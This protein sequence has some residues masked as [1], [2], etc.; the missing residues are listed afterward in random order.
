MQT[1]RGWR[2]WFGK[3]RRLA[4]PENQ[5]ARALGNVAR[6]LESRD[7]QQCGDEGK[8]RECRSQSAANAGCRESLV[9]SIKS[10]AFRYRARSDVDRSFDREQYAWHARRFRATVWAVP[11]GDTPGK[12]DH[13]FVCFNSALEYILIRLADSTGEHSHCRM[14]SSLSVLNSAYF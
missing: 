12:P 1:S 6:F 10:S 2:D 7:Y 8:Q 9:P 13:V 11:A 14:S 5:D 4:A 3:I